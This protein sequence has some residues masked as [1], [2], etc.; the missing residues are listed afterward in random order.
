MGVKELRELLP[1]ELL[2]KEKELKKELFHMRFQHVSG[3]AENPARIGQV[4]R[5]IARVKTIYQEKISQKL[6]G[7][8]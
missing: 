8:H 2:Q 7:E 6:V 3:R 4:K 5:E 1:E